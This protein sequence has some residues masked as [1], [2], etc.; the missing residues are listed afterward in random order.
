M[1]GR[2]SCPARAR[3]TSRARNESER[4]REGRL[5]ERSTV[6]MS[7]MHEWGLGA[8]RL[9]RDPTSGTCAQCA[10]DDAARAPGPEVEPTI[11]PTAVQC[12]VLYKKCAYVYRLFAYID[13]NFTCLLCHSQQFRYLPTESE[14]RLPS[15]CTSIRCGRVTGGA[16]TDF[17][18]RTGT[19]NLSGSQKKR[20]G[21]VA[22]W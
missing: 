4:E 18:Q 13:Y 2:D 5:Y 11:A 7:C 12:T 3:E 6:S 20:S 16:A 22:R 21:S 17:P 14:A 8:S 10:G 15:Q 1:R 9:P 19:R